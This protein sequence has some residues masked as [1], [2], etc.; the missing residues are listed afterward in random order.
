MNK[1]ARFFSESGFW[2][3]MYST[4]LQHYLQKHIIQDAPKPYDFDVV[5][6]MFQFLTF[7]INREIMHALSHFLDKI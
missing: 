4:L 7:H 3:T 6:D 2:D 1:K 5:E